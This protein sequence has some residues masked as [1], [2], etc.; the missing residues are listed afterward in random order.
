MSQATHVLSDLED[1]AGRG[2]AFSRAEAERVLA[3]V[4]LVSV[5]VLGEAARHAH[6]G[7]I[8]TFGR[9]M[10]VRPAAA[11]AALG[12]PAGAGE[13]RVI[14]TPASLPQ[15]LEWVRAASRLASGAPVSGFG[16]ADLVALC[17]DDA[18]ALQSAAETLCEAGLTAVAEIPLDRFPTADAVVKALAAVTAG[19]LGAWRATVER[20]VG[21]ER[22]DLIAR[23]VEVQARTGTLRA[24]APLPRHDSSDLPST[25]YD[26]VR[27][28]AVARLM[29]ATVPRIQVDWP[30]YGPKLAQVAI[31]FGADDIDGIETVDTLNLGPRRAPVEDI[32]RQIRAA[33]AVPAER[34]GRYELRG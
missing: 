13:V 15:A 5:G 6:S 1:K 7:E 20:A 4:D 11:A 27:T 24:F 34:N 22:L 18:V 29:C 31:A 10:T 3:A 32:A 12:D 33:A 9:V 21:P 30:L 14:G 25:G 28:V 26:D 16:L 23:V 2:A 17:G 19:G 8:V